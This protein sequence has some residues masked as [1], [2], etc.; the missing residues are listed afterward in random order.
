MHLVPRK[1]WDI[2]AG[3]TNAYSKRNS[4]LIYALP[5]KGDVSFIPAMNHRIVS[6]HVQDLQRKPRVV[7][8]VPAG[9]SQIISAWELLLFPRLHHSIHPV[10]DADAGEEFKALQILTFCNFC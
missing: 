4:F 3:K 5:K 10:M 6:L 8:Q 7:A 2:Q 1:W 9:C